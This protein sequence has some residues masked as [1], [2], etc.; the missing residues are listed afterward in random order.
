MCIVSSPAVGSTQLPISGKE[1][2]LGASQDTRDAKLRASEFVEVYLHSSICLHCVVLN[3]KVV[4]FDFYPDSHKIG[5]CCLS[6]STKRPG[7]Y[8]CRKTGHVTGRHAVVKCHPRVIAVV[9]Y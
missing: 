1:F 5:K 2:V 7:Q 4:H 6:L 9:V 3:F 8:H